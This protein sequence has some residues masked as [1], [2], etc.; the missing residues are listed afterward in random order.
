M[1]IDNKEEKTL[2]QTFEEIEAIVEQMEAADI[3][4]DASFLLYQQGIEKLKSC[5]QMLDMVE[6]K[7]L[8]LGENGELA[9]F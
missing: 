4:L 1:N 7:M 9:E 6:K 2:E 8:I 3:S 5:N